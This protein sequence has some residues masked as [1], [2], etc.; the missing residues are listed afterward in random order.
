MPKNLLAD[1]AAINALLDTYDELLTSH[2][3]QVMSDYYRYNLSL[4]EIAEQR[5]VS[6]SAIGDMLKQAK[7]SLNQYEKVLHMVAIKQ[8]LKQLMDDATTP[9]T[10]KNQL[11]KILNR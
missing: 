4:Q 10:I 2:Q 1:F 7:L 9:V 11:K 3:R 6:R 5:K 8:T